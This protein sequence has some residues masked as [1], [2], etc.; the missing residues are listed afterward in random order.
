M[1][2]SAKDIALASKGELIQEGAA[3]GFQFDTR[4][5]EKGQWFLALKGAR[6]GHDFIPTALDKQCAG[7]LGQHVP[8][9]WEKGFIAVEDTLIGF[10]NIARWA[11]KKY[12]KPVVGIT[13]SAGKTTTRALIATMLQEY[14]IVHQTSGNFNNHIGVPKTITDAPVD[15]D[16]WVLEMGMSAPGEIALLQDIGKPTIRLISN[17]GAAHVEGCGSIEGVANAKGELFA[18][19]NAGDICCVNMDD[20]RVARLPVPAHAIILTYGSTENC[21]IR[22]LSYDIEDWS[23][24]VS[25]QT[26]KGL[27]QAVIPVPGE[28]MAIN[29]CAAV[30]VGH[31]MGMAPSAIERGLAGYQPVGF[32]MK[33]ERIGSQQFINDSYNANLLSMKAALQMLSKIHS[34]NKL[35]ILGDMLEM[36]ETEEAA[37]LEV[38]LLALRLKIDIAIVGS[39]FQQAYLQLSA[40]Q[41]KEIVHCAES[42]V[43]MAQHLMKMSQPPQTI[44]L[45]GSRGI[46]MERIAEEWR[47][48]VE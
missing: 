8:E 40:E 1:K 36:G 16:V 47:K 25:I 6:D 13:G 19:A 26:P 33:R 29:A 27:V 9:G 44:L 5:L 37:H 20:F 42:S 14:G 17:I 43:E 32:R 18:G 45:K 4:I 7:V 46:R 3:G 30:A 39:R 2:F 24:R 38:L 28:F 48:H 11:R 34:P 31:A 15:T 23:T 12:N 35:A 21:T 22:L 41:Q 10:Q